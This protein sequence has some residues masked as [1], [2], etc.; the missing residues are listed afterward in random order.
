M[1]KKQILNLINYCEF[2]YKDYL[3]EDKYEKTIKVKNKEYDT[4]C[5]IRVK[6][7]IM[8][9]VFRGTVSKTNAITNIKF[10]KKIIPY[11]NS[12]S[13]IRVHRGFMESYKSV[14]EEILKNVS[15]ETTKIIVTGHSYGAA[16]A[17]LGGVD[18]QYNFNK[19]DI[20]VFLFASPRVGN[21]E[22]IKSFNRR[23]FKTYN[24]RNSNDIVTKLPFKF[25]GYDDV[26]VKL[27]IGFPRLFFLFSY[28]QHDLKRYYKNILYKKI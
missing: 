15:D 28:K 2:S 10:C 26:G 22:F 16:L 8:T 21:K 1:Y 14:R 11:N 20:E 17:T 9:V 19:K 18:L 13:K 7:N 24:I 27:N 23:L 4:Y 6:N 12:Q 5:V 25:L 3:S